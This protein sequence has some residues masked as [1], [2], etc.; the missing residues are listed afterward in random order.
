MRTSRGLLLILA[1][2]L[3]LAGAAWYLA[4]A[5]GAS[6][7]AAP[8][9]VSGAD[10][11]GVGGAI[12]AR[13]SAGDESA[14]AREALEAAMPEDLSSIEI[15]GPLVSGRLVDAL[16]HPVADARVLA[17]AGSRG[18]PLDSE[19]FLARRGQR[20]E[21]RSGPDGVFAFDDLQPGA[22][23]FAVRAAGFAP[24]DL[25]G[26]SL[27]P[28]GSLEL[29]EIA[30]EPGIAV[31]GVVT[32]ARGA[33]VEG[34]EIYL[35]LEGGTE[36]LFSP[37]PAGTLAAVS[38]ADGTFRADV[39]P[40]GPWQFQIHAED[41][42]D[43]VVEGVLDSPGAEHAGLRVR[44]EDGGTISGTVFAGRGE[45][46]EELVVRAGRD[47]G[48]SAGPAGRFDLF[49]E[50][51]CDAAG[52]FT[53]RGLTS[54]EL[55]RLRVR[56][57]R[58]DGADPRWLCAPI[59]ALPGERNVEIVL[60]GSASAVFAVRVEGGDAPAEIHVAVESSLRGAR[61]SR[62]RS[63]HQD[64]SQDKGGDGL[65]RL[66][67][68]RLR[69]S[70]LRAG[71][72]WSTRLTVVA[73]GFQPLS[74][75]LGRLAPGEERDLGAIALSELPS[76]VVRV[77]DAA[78]GAPL[79][80]ARVELE[81][82]RS[83]GE[84]QVWVEEDK[85]RRDAA[86]TARAHT[87]E[88]GHARLA[89]P[90]D[91]AGWV[92]AGLEGRAPSLPV[93]VPPSGDGL[94]SVTVALG[95]GGSVDVL[96]L[97]ADGSALPGERV[98]ARPVEAQSGNGPRQRARRTELS[99]AAGRA[100]FENLA[101]GL[102]GFALDIGPRGGV[103]GDPIEVSEGSRAEVVLRAAPRATLEGRVR[104][105]G[106]AL[107][108]ASVALVPGRVR[109]ATGISRDPGRRLHERR[110]DAAGRY[111]FDQAAEGNWTLVVE[112]PS[113][114]LPELR[115]TELHPGA[116]V[117]DVDLGVSLV[118]GTV[119][120]GAGRPLA[121]IRVRMGTG[122]PPRPGQG[123]LVHSSF[124]EVPVWAELAAG[125]AEAISDVDG[126][127][128]LRGA[129]PDVA[130]WVLGEGRDHQPARAEGLRVRQD[131]VL[132]GVDL[133]LQPAGRLA[134]RVTAAGMP[135]RGVAV[136]PRRRLEGGGLEHGQPAFTDALGHAEL[137]G[138]APG[139]WTLIA[140]ARNRRPPVERAVEVAAGKTV[141][142]E[143]ELE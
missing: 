94:R 106:R 118:E 20:S 75:E 31:S 92:R 141:E 88:N 38:A 54:T 32:D 40:P 28:G 10:S 6:A 138:L 104:E 50:A 112:H 62:T 99:D 110:T 130:L 105:S 116:N 133:V 103:R 76:L 129:P 53:L 22:L 51:G 61:E 3:S 5:R 39:L 85:G 79:E 136:W 12:S 37:R 87:D 69:L 34:A 4:S 73:Q 98:Q 7:A 123:T 17:A 18:W 125:G 14:S 137:R 64:G 128:E 25:E 95:F 27:P 100:R 102:Y 23:R 45:R 113:R 81:L 42:P 101:P 57:A 107:V 96:V 8:A 84:S 97:D 33:P 30:L 90:R 9:E 77:V 127:W 24:L 71:G 44:L 142:I 66:A 82:E 122:R 47:P 29:G 86:R 36:T 135:A 35:P 48:G 58:D 1:L 83:G 91:A 11:V 78:S 74:L 117:L 55:H 80:G 19:L 2:A 70:G 46:L 59:E 114:A 121:G 120:D 124:A 16:G 119:R 56:A 140:S 68:G 108:G 43:A 41:H 134:V 67:D 52:R 115:P 131:S 111:A 93:E 26:R 15:G 65:E 109:D 139:A 143:L 49:R 132:S 89:A 126:R 21:T 72:E 13:S 63:S 60:A